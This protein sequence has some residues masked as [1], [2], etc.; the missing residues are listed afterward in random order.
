MIRAVWMTLIPFTF[1]LATPPAF[2]E[3]M[4]ASFYGAESGKRTASGARFNP[5][6]LTAAHKTLPFGTRLRVCYRGCA[7]VTVTDRGPFVRGRQLDISHGAA[8]VIG[9]T[10]PG[11]ARVTVERL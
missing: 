9:L 11:V 4:V 8:R 3:T 2:S 6:G 7:D 5:N 10:G 1:L